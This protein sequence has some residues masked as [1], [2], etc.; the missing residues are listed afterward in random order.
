MNMHKN[1]RLTLSFPR[2]EEAHCPASMLRAWR[3]RDLDVQCVPF[4]PIVS[5]VVGADP[6][7]IPGHVYRRREYRPLNVVRSG[8][9]DNGVVRGDAI[10]R[11]RRCGR[12]LSRRQD[13]E[14][15]TRRCEN[16]TA[17]RTVAE[18]R[19]SFPGLNVFRHKRFQTPNAGQTG[20]HL[21]ADSGGQR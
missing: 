8:I 9:C 7:F 21:A 4:D 10:V 20:R 19:L 15:L 6:S 17:V 3:G 16:Q 12:A 1:A 18:N 13:C 5:N 14:Y 2:Q 11:Q